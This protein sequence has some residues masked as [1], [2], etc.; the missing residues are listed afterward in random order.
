MLPANQELSTP[1][2][3]ICECDL[4]NIGASGGTVTRTLVWK[5]SPFLNTSGVSNTY[6]TAVTFVKSVGLE[7]Y[8]PF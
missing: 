6:F 2:E 8:V 7:V 4:V 3:N 1:R 5:F